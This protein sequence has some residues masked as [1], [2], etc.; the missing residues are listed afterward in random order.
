MQKSGE[1]ELSASAEERQRRPTHRA[2]DARRGQ[3]GGVDRRRRL[4]GRGAAQ[5]IAGI[6]LR[7]PS[8]VVQLRAGR[9][10]HHDRGQRGGLNGAIYSASLM[11]GFDF[12]QMLEVWLELADIES[13]ARSTKAQPGEPARPSLFEGENYFRAKFVERL[14]LW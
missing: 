13:L 4:R 7:S 1:F 9:G 6:D 3:P 12:D 8:G 11:Y 10:R 14:R 2:G 5:G